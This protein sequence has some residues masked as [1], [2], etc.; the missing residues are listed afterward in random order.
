MKEGQWSDVSSVGTLS[1]LMMYCSN[2]YA[3]VNA[4]YSLVANTL[5]YSS[6]VARGVCHK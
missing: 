2:K 5:G 1:Q 6:E 4:I 3:I